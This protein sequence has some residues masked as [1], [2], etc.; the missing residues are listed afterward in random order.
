MRIF[1]GNLAWSVTSGELEELFARAGTV[2]DALVLTDSLS[3]R[4]RG[5]GFVE[6]PDSEARLAIQ[7]FD[8]A[9]FKGRALR[10]NE[11]HARWR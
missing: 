3:G 10:V 7:Q 11:E 5:F 2:S 8:G 6:M 4:S 9:E 1:I